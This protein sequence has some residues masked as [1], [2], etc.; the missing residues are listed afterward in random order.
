MPNTG[1]ARWECALDYP[2]RAGNRNGDEPVEEE[3]CGSEPSKLIRG[4]EWDLYE[5][6]HEAEDYPE[7]GSARVSAQQ[8]RVLTPS[9]AGAHK[10]ANNHP[11][12][13]PLQGDRD[14][15]RDGTEHIGEDPN[16][17]ETQWIIAV[18]GPECSHSD[19]NE[20]SK[21]TNRFLAPSHLDGGED[22]R[23]SEGDDDCDGEVIARC[24]IGENEEHGRCHGLH[25]APGS[26]HQDA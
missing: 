6:T 2:P 24:E 20:A 12:E 17:E 16:L 4:D 25:C 19:A 14:S 8:I 7:P 26:T 23:N 22:G 10:R 1:M 5:C 15:E 9:H 3:R 11:D 13:R 18:S 21:N